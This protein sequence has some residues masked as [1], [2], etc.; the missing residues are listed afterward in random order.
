MLTTDLSLRLDP[1]Y[2]KISRIASWRTRRVRRRLRPRV[3]QADPPRHGPGARYLGKEV[4]R[5]DLIWQDPHPAVNHKLIDA[6]DIA[7]L[8]G[9]ILASG[10]RLADSFD[11]LGVGLHLPRLR[12]A[13]RRQRRAHS[14][15]AAEGLGGQPAGRAGEGAQDAG[16]HPERVPQD[17]LRRQ[18]G[19]AGRPDRS[20]WLR[21]RGGRG[22]EGW[23]RRD[24]AV[25]ARTHG[26][27]AGAD[28]R[29]VLRRARAEGRR[30]P[31][32]PQGQV[33]RAAQRPC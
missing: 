4:P 20:G 2:A 19:V 21:G 32:L 23:A 16:G 14:P 7:A 31:Q 6:Q 13:R 8:K 1:D 11:R 3:V 22:E 30:L 33:Q 26:R 10:C 29:G 28:R 18:E 5:E 9:K 25:H 27:L 15:R 17:G 12:Q 24:G